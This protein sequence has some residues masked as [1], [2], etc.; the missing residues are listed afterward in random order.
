MLNSEALPITRDDKSPAWVKIRPA[1]TTA[2]SSLTC[3]DRVLPRQ[4]SFHGNRDFP[5]VSIEIARRIGR[6]K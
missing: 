4:I 5:A 2:S 3:G 1:A 6:E